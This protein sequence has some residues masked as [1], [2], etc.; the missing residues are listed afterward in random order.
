MFK[1]FL[2]V[3]LGIIEICILICGVLF[4]LSRASLVFSTY[5]KTDN[6]PDRTIMLFYELPKDSVD[7]VFVGD[8]HSYNSYIPQMIFD[9]IGVSSASLATSSTS[10]LNMYWEL[11]E[12]FNRQSPKM[13]VLE[14]HTLK[15]IYDSAMY[16]NSMHIT[17]GLYMMEDISINKYL[18]LKDMKDN[19]YCVS[20]D[21]NYED[22]I[23]FLI[24]RTDKDREEY[25]F[26]KLKDFIMNPAKS[27]ETFG[28]NPRTEIHPIFKIDKGL[29]ETYIDINKTIEFSYLKK[30]YELCKENDCEL[31]LSLAPFYN[32]KETGG[33]YNQIEDWAD[34]NNI[35]YFDYFDLSEEIELDVNLDFNDG[36]HLNYWGAQKITDY[37]INYINNN[38]NLKDHHGDEKYSLW[39]FNGVDYSEFDQIL[40]KIEKEME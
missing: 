35:K 5:G 24:F 32:N 10:I 33:I 8:S 7:V 30:I 20:N 4:V 22:I 39:E 19:D 16:D 25:T 26:N 23:S 1:K 13:V 34:I 12:T 9:E 17:S 2:K 14:M 28:Y 27:F 38:Y 3:L 6:D 40:D 29:S 21:L 37:F 11:K 15:S 18:C 31:I 36:K